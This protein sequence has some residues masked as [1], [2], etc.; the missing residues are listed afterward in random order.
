MEKVVIGH[1]LDVLCAGMAQLFRARYQGITAI[2]SPCFKDMMTAIDQYSPE[3]ILM[4]EHFRTEDQLLRVPMI[5]DRHPN[6]KIVVIATLPRWEKGLHYL[7]HGAMAYLSLESIT[8]D[9]FFTAI[10][11]ALEGHT[12]YSKLMKKAILKIR[13]TGGI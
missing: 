7:D 9:E 4:D 11:M 8:T 6:A 13:P 12:Y 5:L 10:D 1:R 2:E 3:L